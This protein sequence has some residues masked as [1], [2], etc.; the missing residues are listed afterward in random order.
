MEKAP[1]TP[2]ACRPEKY[3]SRLKGKRVAFVGNQTSSV[4]GRHT[5]DFLLENG[6][7]VVRIFGPEHGFREMADDATPVKDRM[8]TVTGLP[9]VS[10][11]GDIEKPTPE[12][13]K[14]IEVFVYDI[15]DVGVRFYTYI[16]TLSFI[17]EAA[18]EAGFI[19]VVF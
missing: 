4:N 10:L 6:V 19:V 15:Q 8:D 13:L 2:G 18:G 3:L 5:L 17:M 12:H 7:E 1:I 11:F 16:S 14:D 9:V